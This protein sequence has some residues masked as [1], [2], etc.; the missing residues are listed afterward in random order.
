VDVYIGTSGW[1]YSWNPKRSLDWYIENTPFNAIEV[2]STFYHTPKNQ[3]IKKW[4]PFTEKLRFVIKV[5]RSITHLHRFN[6]KA[7]GEWNK[8]YEVFLDLE[9]FIDYYLF[10]IPPSIRIN[11]L[12][13]IVKFYEFTKLKEKFAF[14]PRN[15]EWFDDNIINTIKKLGIT[16]VSVSAPKL[17]DKIILNLYSQVYMRFHGKERWYSYYYKNDEIIKYVEEIKKLNPKKIYLFFNNDYMLENGI[18]MWELL[19][20]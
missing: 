5:N 6:D 2:N 19:K 7:M 11:Y 4:L 12:E 3:T 10:Q 16:I 14:E 8:F 17:P 9:P 20:S 15:I 13:K 18:T 1:N